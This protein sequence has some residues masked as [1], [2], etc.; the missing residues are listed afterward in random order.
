MT[1]VATSAG[2]GG[3][4]EGCRTLRAQGGDCGAGVVAPLPF[5]TTQITSTANYSSPQ[6]GDVCHPLAAGAHPPAVAFTERSRG[7]GRSL[8]TQEECAY[9]LTN[10]GSGG[11][12]HSRQKLAGMQVRRLT[13]RECERLQALPD[14]WTR[15]REDGSEVSDS[16]RYRMLGNAVTASVSE[17]IGRRLV[18]VAGC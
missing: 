3:W 10:P 15:W 6:P 4:R 18:E 2:H 17:W 14:D 9:A 7:D 5:D 8:E 1:F 11:R 16:A 12:T 13:P